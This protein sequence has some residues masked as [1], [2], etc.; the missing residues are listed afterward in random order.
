VP[1]RRGCARALADAEPRP[2]RGAGG[3]QGQRH[4]WR[5]SGLLPR[6]AAWYVSLAP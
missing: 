2:S 4:V 3:F 1:P 6:R 5:R